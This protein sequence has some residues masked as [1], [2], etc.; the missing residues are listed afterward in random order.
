MGW[1]GDGVCDR[2]GNTASSTSIVAMN[3]ARTTDTR[4]R[5]LGRVEARVFML[6]FQQSK[7]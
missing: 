2:A 3:S 5:A 7:G 4:A 1:I 6:F